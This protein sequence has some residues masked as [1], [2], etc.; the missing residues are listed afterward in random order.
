MEEQQRI[1]VK[2]IIN[3]KVE[4]T[5]E[6]EYRNYGAINYSTLSRLASSPALVEKGIEKTDSMLLGSL[7]DNLLTKGEY[8]DEYYL[9]T[10]E[11]PSGQLGKYCDLFYSS[12]KNGYDE[13][14]SHSYAYQYSG[15]K[16][17]KA[18]GMIENFNKS[19]IEY[20]NMLKESE[21]KELVPLEIIAK[22]N[23]V[24]QRIKDSEASWLFNKNNAPAGIE[25]LHQV[26]IVYDLPEGGEGK[27]LLDIVVVDHN[28]EEVTPYDLKTTSSSSSDFRF[29][30][31]KWKYYLQASLY[32]YGL[33]SICKYSV[34]NFKFIT[35]STTY[36]EPPVIWK[37]SNMDLM[38]G[39]QGIERPYSNER[40]KG[41]EELIAELEWHTQNTS[42][43]LPYGYHNE[44]ITI[45]FFSK[46][47]K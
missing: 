10:V 29:S 39:R 27:A 33:S 7:V 18:E 22:A 9:A 36:N 45:D 44:E 17:P 11:K 23:A 1:D 12:M 13:E 26:A 46:W 5:S 19:G 6:K 28:K 20:V 47:I 4:L 42:W 15:I 32:H 37:C 41:W 3:S 14:Q 16:R 8:G 30:F 35:V 21:G 40:V 34:N 43:D 2:E 31:S 25:I 38:V 24:V